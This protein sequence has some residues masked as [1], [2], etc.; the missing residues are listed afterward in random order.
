MA[1]NII[2]T[3]DFNGDDQFTGADLDITWAYLQIKRLYELGDATI[4]A[5]N[6]KQKVIDQYNLN[7]DNFLAEPSSAEIRIL[8]GAAE[9][10]LPSWSTT[11]DPVQYSRLWSVNDL[12]SDTPNVAW[13]RPT[14]TPG[15][16]YESIEASTTGTISG[17][18]WAHPSDEANSPILILWNAGK[19][20]LADTGALKNNKSWTLHFRVTVRKLDGI[21]FSKGTFEVKFFQGDIIGVLSG[22]G[23]KNWFNYPSGKD[24]SEYNDSTFDFYFCR[25]GQAVTMFMDTGN[26]PEECP[27]SVMGSLPIMLSRSDYTHNLEFHGKLVKHIS[28]IYITDNILS[29][30]LPYFTNPPSY[31]LRHDLNIDDSWFSWKNVILDIYGNGAYF[32]GAAGSSQGHWYTGSKLTS[33]LHFGFVP[34]SRCLVAYPNQYLRVDDMNFSSNWTFSCWIRSKGTGDY[35]PFLKFHFTK[36]FEVG[37]KWNGINTKLPNGTEKRIIVQSMKDE[38]YPTVDNWHHVTLVRNRSLIGIWLNGEYLDYLVAD[39][40]AS[41]GLTFCELRLGDGKG[42]FM[43]DVRVLNYAMTHIPANGRG[44][45]TAWSFIDELKEVSPQ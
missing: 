26:G 36:T 22:S 24:G 13:S 27:Q 1:V 14:T 41:D 29:G 38:S 35:Y 30:I 7:K 33:G 6:F 21:M 42:V 25:E 40:T 31:R 17:H 28:D 12:F 20:S 9:T 32:D 39:E 19:I 44:N 37:F 16:L 45:Q 4:T 3:I 34:R 5:D 15:D 18:E 43:A 11:E 2:E 8:P 10:G 23:V